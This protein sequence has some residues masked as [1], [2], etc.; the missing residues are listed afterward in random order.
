MNNNTVFETIRT[1]CIEKEDP[2]L[3]DLDK[4]Y[5]AVAHGYY[6]VKPGKNARDFMHE[7]NLSLIEGIK[8]GVEKYADM[9]CPSCISDYTWVSVAKRTL[10]VVRDFFD[11]EF[12]EVQSRTTSY[13]ALDPN[14]LLVEYLN[15]MDINQ[16]E[17]FRSLIDHLAFESNI[18]MEEPTISIISV[19]ANKCRDIDINI[20][21]QEKEMLN[22]IKFIQNKPRFAFD[23][24]DKG[25][26]AN[27]INDL[28]T[29]DRA[30]A[31]NLARILYYTE[32]IN[33][34]L[35]YVLLMNNYNR[36][37]NAHPF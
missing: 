31:V 2:Q 12:F 21:D 34:G 16:I 10:K 3:Y 13:E 36:M 15:K 17:K 11:R 37:C 32:D 26:I 5:T 18:F 35:E 30:V 24:L 4:V 33:L 8:D 6:F 1:L 25:D 27:T 22:W 7:L 29:K 19:L 9:N 28:I 14:V 23:Y 20:P